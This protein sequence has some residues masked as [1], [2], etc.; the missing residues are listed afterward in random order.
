M[1]QFDDHFFPNIAAAAAADVSRNAA[2]SNITFATFPHSFV[3]QKSHRGARR[4]GYDRC[5][6]V[7]VD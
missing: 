7:L 3:K 2:A 1:M 5:E 4:Q 6:H